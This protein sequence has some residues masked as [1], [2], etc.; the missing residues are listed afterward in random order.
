MLHKSVT[1]STEDGAVGVELEIVPDEYEPY[2]LL[3]ACDAFGE[4]I[5][6]CRVRPD[7]RLNTASA[8]AWIEGGYRKPA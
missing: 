8:R 1:V 4:E 6:R 3:S 7:F 2:A 5:A